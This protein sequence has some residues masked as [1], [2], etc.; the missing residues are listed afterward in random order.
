MV[1]RKREDSGG[2]SVG[3]FPTN[4]DREV[5]SVVTTSVGEGTSN[6]PR[7]ATT[8]PVPP[9]IQMSTC[10]TEVATPDGEGTCLFWALL[11]QAGYKVW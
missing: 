10:A 2:N 8:S 1:K 6:S 5:G 11:T 4:V 7:G 3:E 9:N